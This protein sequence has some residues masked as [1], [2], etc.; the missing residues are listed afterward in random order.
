M[1]VY[2][3]IYVLVHR[4]AP[5]HD[6]PR[7]AFKSAPVLESNSRWICSAPLLFLQLRCQQLIKKMI[8]TKTSQDVK[9][10]TF[11]DAYLPVI[12]AEDPSANSTVFLAH[13][14]L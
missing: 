7:H 3:Y 5:A 13:L 8:P 10:E 1:Y 11:S 9:R 2:M 4:A 12:M 6:L 14:H